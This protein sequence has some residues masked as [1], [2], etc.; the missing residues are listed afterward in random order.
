[1]PCVDAVG[2]RGL[3]HEI[4]LAV[5]DP[6]AKNSDWD[7]QL[8]GPPSKPGQTFYDQHKATK[9]HGTAP[10]AMAVRKP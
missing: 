8:Y 3:Q 10:T 1:M 9:Q 5:G 6:E 4:E 2:V 7:L